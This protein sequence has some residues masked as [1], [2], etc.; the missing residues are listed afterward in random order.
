MIFNSTKIIS[1]IHIK[2]LVASTSCP[3]INQVLVG[4]RYLLD[5]L[6]EE[7]S[8]IENGAKCTRIDILGSAAI[9]WWDNRD[10][11]LRRQ[12]I[13]VQKVVRQQR[14][15]EE[16]GKIDEADPYPGT[17]LMRF[18]FAPAACQALADSD[19]GPTS[20]AGRISV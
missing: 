13:S 4:K 11:I 1:I 10:R 14:D 16:R 9:S 15:T 8:D 17:S 2:Y 7:E 5:T 6:H 18:H 19:P 12:T 20:C 3:A